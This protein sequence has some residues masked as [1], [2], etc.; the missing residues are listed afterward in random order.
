MKSAAVRRVHERHREHAIDDLGLRCDEREIPLL[1][2]PEVTRNLWVGVCRFVA[3]PPGAAVTGVAALVDVTETFAL[4]VG[5]GRI[6][7]IVSPDHRSQPAIWFMAPISELVVE[8]TGTHGLVR[9]RPSSVLVRTPAWQL[10]TT[11]VALL[12]RHSFQSG[13][14]RSFISALTDGAR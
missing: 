12:L 4:A 3:P 5:Q 1:L 6:G 8:P 2:A 14:E 11:D 7:G 13:Q 9:K 10:R